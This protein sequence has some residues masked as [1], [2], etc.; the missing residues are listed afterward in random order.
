[1]HSEKFVNFVFD[2][3]RVMINLAEAVC[4]IGRGHEA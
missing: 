3:D 4:G 2:L 1:M